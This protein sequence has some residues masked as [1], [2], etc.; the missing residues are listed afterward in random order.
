MRRYLTIFTVIILCLLFI[1]CRHRETYAFLNSTDEIVSISVVKISLSD[2]GEVIQTAV[3]EIK[4]IKAF[5]DHFKGIACYTHYGDP[6]GISKEGTEDNVI[7]IF[8]ENDE[9]E[10]INWSGQAEYTSKY[11]FRYY[12]GYS[13]FDEMQFE[14]LIEEYLAN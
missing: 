12:A 13:V 6:L 7:K 11:G 8:Y 10:L 14:A 9:Y 5:L 2:N 4:D 3:G 1:S